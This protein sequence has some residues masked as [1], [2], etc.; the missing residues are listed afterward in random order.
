MNSGR[1]L[2]VHSTQVPCAHLVVPHVLL[3]VLLEHVVGMLVVVVLLLHH[4]RVLLHMLQLLVL[5]LLHQ[6]YRN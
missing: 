5:Q 3:R 4:V 1:G 2:A 6:P